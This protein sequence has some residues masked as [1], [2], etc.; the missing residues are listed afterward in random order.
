MAA[1]SMR[2]VGRVNTLISPATHS[3]CYAKRSRTF[4]G[5]DPSNEEGILA[6][7][8]TVCA[9]LSLVLAWLDSKCILL[10]RIE[11]VDI[12]GSKLTPFSG[13]R[14]GYTVGDVRYGRGGGAG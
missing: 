9:F 14:S 6:A 7:I 11:F 2:E 5:A 12:F 1:K 10:V 8:R 3:I 4:F 13:G